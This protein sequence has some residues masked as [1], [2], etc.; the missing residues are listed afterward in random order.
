MEPPSCTD[1]AR[2]V[3]TTAAVVVELLSLDDEAGL[4]LL[5]LVDVRATTPA[6]APPTRAPE[7]AAMA[8][9]RFGESSAIGARP[10]TAARRGAYRRR[11]VAGDRSVGTDSGAAHHDVAGRSRA[12]DPP[13][14]R[15]DLL[16][17]DLVG[18]LER[19]AV[20]VHIGREFGFI[21]G[22]RVGVVR[23]AVGPHAVDVLQQLGLGRRGWNRV[24]RP[25]K[26]SS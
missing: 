3:R 19:R 11:P 1:V 13:R 25:Q 20:R 14:W 8:A 23:D 10:A 2:V 15:L 22:A 26:A 6:T 12:G 21:V 5:P 18:V 9:I 17:A 4:S 16:A 24:G 7:M